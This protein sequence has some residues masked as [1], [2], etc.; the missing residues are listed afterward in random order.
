MARF[1]LTNPV[2]NLAAVTATGAGAA[3]TA[4]A[5]GCSVWAITAASITSGGTVKIQGSL[6]D[7]NYYDIASVAVTANGTQYVFVDEPHFYLR[8]N[9]TAR[10][11]GTYTVKYSLGGA[12]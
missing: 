11:D 4:S 1:G 6:D 9:V 12:R 2:S 8:A 10:T 5:S 7:T 3:V